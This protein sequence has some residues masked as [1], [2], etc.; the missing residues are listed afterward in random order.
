MKCFSYEHGEMETRFMMKAKVLLSVVLFLRLL[1]SGKEL[2]KASVK[3]YMNF[4][5][6]N[7][8]FNEGRKSL[9]LQ[10]FDK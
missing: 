10:Q 4:K 8:I 2:L 6:P 1:Q 3:Q 5:L 9:A 7:F